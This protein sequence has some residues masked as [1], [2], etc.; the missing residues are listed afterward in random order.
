MKEKFDIRILIIIVLTIILAVMC[1]FY[2]KEDNVQ[3]QSRDFGN[4][5]RTRTE[6]TR[7][8]TETVSISATGSVASSVDE[9]LELEE[10]YYIEEVYIEKNEKVSEGEYILKYTNGDYL[11]APYDCIINGIKVPDDDKKCTSQHY[12]EIVSS[13]NL[14]VQL[15]VDE[16]KVSNLS[17]GDEAEIE[18]TAFDNKIITG[19]IT[20][21]S[22]S[23][24]NGKFNVTI[25]FENDGKIMIGMTA[26]VSVKKSGE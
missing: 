10:G 8:S 25:E 5:T 3:V 7:S 26:K 17:V 2:F 21:I 19:K 13:N 24:S 4:V 18:I 1:Y 20:N 16:T 23:A 15:K 6:K 11:T 22:N 12:I 14:M 9:K